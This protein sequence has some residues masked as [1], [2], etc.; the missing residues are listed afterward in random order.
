MPRELT[1][2]Q[3]Y[4]N[5]EVMSRF[6]LGKK[7]DKSSRTYL[8]DIQGEIIPVVIARLSALYVRGQS[9]EDRELRGSHLVSHEDALAY[10]TETIYNCCG[11]LKS[12]VDTGNGAPYWEPLTPGQFRFALVW[13][14]HGINWAKNPKNH[15][16]AEAVHK[17]T[18]RIQSAMT[19]A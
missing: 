3:R 6:G 1:T 14:R 16:V 15:R 10:A 5:V 11:D 19:A 8:R 4:A 13:F 2:P 12:L 9:E 17:R 18:S 7:N